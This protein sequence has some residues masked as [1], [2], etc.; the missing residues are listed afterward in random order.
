MAWVQAAIAV[1]SSLLS[2]AMQPEDDSWKAD[3]ER[4][5]QREAGLL[6][7]RGRA[8]ALLPAQARA[9]SEA[10][11]AAK[12]QTEQDA[13]AAQSSAAV[14]AAAAG[15]TGISVDQTVSQFDTTAEMVREQLDR[16]LDA[17]LLQ[18]DQDAED[19]V[20]DAEM[21]KY[22]VKVRNTG[23]VS[24]TQALLAAGLSGVSAYLANR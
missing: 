16:Q 22:D 8:L 23:G 2:S 17:K 7:N 5:G 19:I 13:V 21:Q 14:Q 18:I 9:E 24:G 15:V 20:W 4:A 11:Q 10:A 3:A 12:L 6:A 1:G